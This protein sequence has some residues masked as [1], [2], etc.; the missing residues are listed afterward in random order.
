MEVKTIVSGELNN[1]TYVVLNNQKAIIVDASAD[2]SLI[3]GVL[4]GREVDGVLLSHAH[5]DHIEHLK[6][7]LKKYNCKCFLSASA[8]P[9]FSD[10][11][12]NASYLSS[13]FMV[14]IAKDS[15]CIVK[16][17]D[18][19]TLAGLKIKVIELKGHTDCGLG[20][21]IEDVVFS[22]DTMF[23]DGYGRTDLPTSDFTKLIASLKKLMKNYKGYKLLSGHGP[24]GI[25]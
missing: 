1:N 21:V 19:L 24:E 7:I 23:S 12:L 16:D 18:N 3:D 9:K 4:D 2:V 5:F 6:D 10:A 14:D 11:H 25:I 22:G 8:V 13:P 17:E 20:F 15:L